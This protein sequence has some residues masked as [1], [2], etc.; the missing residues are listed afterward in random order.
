MKRIAIAIDEDTLDAARAY[1]KGQQIS[2]SALVRS[3]LTEA[4]AR[5]RQSA[6]DE[7]FRLMSAYPGNSRGQE[8]DRD[9]LYVR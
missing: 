8:W 2:L 5:D 1:A 3:L 7:M 6:V 4:V 9:D